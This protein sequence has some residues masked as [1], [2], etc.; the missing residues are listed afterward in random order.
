MKRPT[1]N[2]I[3]YSSA[4]ANV[5]QVNRSHKKHSIHIN[6]AAMCIYHFKCKTLSLYLVQKSFYS[7]SLV[8]CSPSFSFSLSLTVSLSL[9]AAG[10]KFE[11]DWLFKGLT[12]VQPLIDSSILQVFNTPPPPHHHYQVSLMH[13]CAVRTSYIKWIQMCLLVL[14]RKHVLGFYHY[15]IKGNALITLSRLSEGK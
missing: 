11:I 12:E 7:H 8:T 13:R 6:M 14:N 15:R 3:H 4:R 10:D 5:Q 1:C 9:S 2:I